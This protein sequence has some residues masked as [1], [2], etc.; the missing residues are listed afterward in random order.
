MDRITQIIGSRPIEP[1]VLDQDVLEQRLWKE[2]RLFH[3]TNQMIFVFGSNEAGIHGGGAARDAHHNHSALMRCGFGHVMW[4]FAI[5][6]KG[7]IFSD[8]MDA[9]IGKTL[10]IPEIKV[11]VDAFLAY[12]RAQ[13]DMT[14]QVTQLGCGLAGLKKEDIAPM[15]YTAPKNCLFDTEW[16]PLLPAT[17]KFW[18]TFP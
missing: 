18:G 10:S 13:K 12:A 11:Y 8:K 17:A 3:P 2:G 9:G 4:S 1:S 14:F 15:F 7:A 16:E 6:T 5:P